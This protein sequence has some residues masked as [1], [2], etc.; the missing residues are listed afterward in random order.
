VA[1]TTANCGSDCGGGGGG[2]GGARGGAGSAGA[3]G[4]ST[5]REY[6]PAGA[7]GSAIYSV[8]QEGRTLTV[9]GDTNTLAAVSN[10]LARIDRPK[11]QVMIKVVFLE[12][13]YN[14][15]VDIGL[16]GSFTKQVNS[17]PP[18]GVGLTNLFGLAQQG[19]TPTPN[20]N[21]LPGAGLYS[22]TGN[23]FTATLRAI[24]EVGKVQI[25]SR[26]IILARNNQQANIVV[27]QEVP[28][29]TGVSYDT[30]GNEHSS[31]SYQ[32]VG[33][34]LTV[35][36]FITPDDNVEMMVAPQIS[37]VASQSTQ[38][39]SGTNGSFS[40]PYINIRSANTVVVTP[41]GQT[42]VIGGLMQD[43]KSTT[44][45]KI[46]VLGNIPLLGALFH[47]KVIADAKTELMIFLTPYIVRTPRDLIVVSQDERR[48]AE[49]PPKT[50]PEKK[51]NQ[52]LSPTTQ[53]DS[54]PPSTPASPRTH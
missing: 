44:D 48:R 1:A 18:I 26:P 40:T 50:F 37:E 38:I 25:L 27:G 9:I 23:D 19:I 51:M 13:T 2:G 53:P 29:I 24:Q 12:V 6:P 3:G 34:I 4:A 5:T 41:N 20:V 33:I 47:H 46:P 10:A 8:D 42:V 22:V 39:S 14:N 54:T 28:L 49:V 30:F 35:T 45:S 17:G 31:I 32:N 7:V 36:P 43:S 21:T 16:E 15:G 11:P 52:Y